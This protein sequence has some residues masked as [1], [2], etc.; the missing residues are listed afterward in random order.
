[1]AQAFDCKAS[2]V[3]LGEPPR[4][5]PGQPTTF[6]PRVP[7]LG[8]VVVAGG[9][10]ALFLTAVILLWDEPDANLP[11]IALISVALLGFA[12]NQF[13]QRAELR[14]LILGLLAKGRA[15]TGFVKAVESV[16]AQGS[17]EDRYV[18]QFVD[19]AKVRREV[20]GSWRN[21]EVQFRKAS[22]VVV[23]HEVGRPDRFA[24]FP[25][26]YPDLK[27]GLPDPL[28]EMAELRALSA[29]YG[30]GD[31][32]STSTEGAFVVE[33][34]RAALG[35]A[36]EQLEASDALGAIESLD[37]AAALARRAGAPGEVVDMIQA[38]RNSAVRR[39]EE[40]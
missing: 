29:L 33:R 1:M 18:F 32:A 36:A 21:A 7:G 4:S 30:S 2:V 16:R 5:F 14:R 24:V 38:R 13:M 35:G 20:K 6:L 11:V 3:A 22:L 15:T 40:A 9:L 34:V 10:G 19:G 12:I 31:P 26:D 23:L 8:A 27:L 25:L 17:V 39:F 37:A 28:S